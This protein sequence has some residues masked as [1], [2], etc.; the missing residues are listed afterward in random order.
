MVVRI[1]QAW[2]PNLGAQGQTMVKFTIQR[3][4]KLTNVEVERPSG[5]TTLD[6][7]AMRAILST[8]ALTPLPDAFPNPTLT[9]HLNFQY[10]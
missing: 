8:R 5:T 10:Q 7:A 6:L 3:D 1:R 4:G 9:V 2:T